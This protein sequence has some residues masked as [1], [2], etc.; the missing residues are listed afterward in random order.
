[1]RTRRAARVLEE[2]R[3]D[4]LD[5]AHLLVHLADVAAPGPG[6]LLEELA[7]A[8]V[9]R[10]VAVLGEQEAGRGRVDRVHHWLL[11][12]CRHSVGL[13][14]A[15]GGEVRASSRPPPPDTRAGA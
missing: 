9:H 7:A 4:L 15:R 2:E 11:L 12:S 8:D 3:R 14:A 10:H 5:V 1:S 6:G 13:D